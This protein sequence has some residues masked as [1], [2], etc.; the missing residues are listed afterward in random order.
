M[1]TLYCTFKPLVGWRVVFSLNETERNIKVVSHGP[2]KYLRIPATQVIRH[3]RFCNPVK[4]TLTYI[5]QERELAWKSRQFRNRL[6]Q[7]YGASSS[8][9]SGVDYAR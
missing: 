6:F 8:C 9:I 2:N 5:R 1:A 4:Q 3:G 7:S